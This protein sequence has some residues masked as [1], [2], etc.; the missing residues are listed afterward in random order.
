MVSDWFGP[1]RFFVLPSAVLAA[2]CPPASSCLQLTYRKET[3]GKQ[4]ARIPGLREDVKRHSGRDPIF[5]LAML[6]SSKPSLEQRTATSI[7]D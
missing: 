2:S 7:V 4:V 3:K 1:S 5:E 6:N